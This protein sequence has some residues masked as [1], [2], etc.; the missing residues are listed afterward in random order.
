MSAPGGAIRSGDAAVAG[1][2]IT[3][4]RKLAADGLAARQHRHGPTPQ[5]MSKH[6]IATAMNTICGLMVL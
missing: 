6:K 4:T 3:R 5:R 1:Q 2:R